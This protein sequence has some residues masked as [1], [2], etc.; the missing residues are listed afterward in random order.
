MLY[1][2]PLS[3]LSAALQINIKAA[4]SKMN[5]SNVTGVVK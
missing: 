2:N 1:F 4:V 3:G 5:C